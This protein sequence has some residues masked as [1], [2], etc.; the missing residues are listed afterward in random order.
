MT[1]L[2]AVDDLANSDITRL[3]VSAPETVCR[4]D[5]GGD[6][7]DLVTYT[8]RS[9]VNQPVKLRTTNIVERISYSLLSSK[10]C[11]IQDWFRCSRCGGSDISYL[12]AYLLRQD[13]QCI[14]KL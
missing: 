6:D 1:G 4:W 13:L 3:P 5:G 9:T 12:L 2:P 14:S 10:Q 8:R 7:D 11:R